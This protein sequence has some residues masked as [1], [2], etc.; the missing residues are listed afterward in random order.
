MPRECFAGGV[1]ASVLDILVWKQLKELI[2]SPELVRKQA[3]R[4]MDSKNASPAK[5]KIDEAKKRLTLN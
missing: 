5:L 1:N 3:A 4:W 2:E